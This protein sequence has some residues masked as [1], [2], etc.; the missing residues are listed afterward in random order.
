MM[1]T[2]GWASERFQAK[3]ATFSSLVAVND[4]RDWQRR[5][6]TLDRMLA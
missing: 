4:E 2:D 6:V 1:W 5:T 3:D